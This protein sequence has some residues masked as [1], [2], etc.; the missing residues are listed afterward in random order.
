M[1]DVVSDVTEVIDHS[2]SDQ[3]LAQDIGV[4]SVPRMPSLSDETR[5]VLAFASTDVWIAFVKDMNRMFFRD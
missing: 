3:T 1:P 4:E 2:W 5:N